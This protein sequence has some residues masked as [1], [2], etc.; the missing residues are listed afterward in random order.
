[1]TSVTLRAVLD[2]QMFQGLPERE[3]RRLVAVARRRRFERR[4][5]VFHQGDP[6]D[7]LHLVSR[8]H[9]AAR[10]AT[11]LGNTTTLSVHGPGEAFGELAIV[12]PDSARSTT[13]AALEAGE[14]YAVHRTDFGRL[15]EQ[16]PSVND[17]LV[18]LLARRLR[19][20]GDLLAEALFVPAE[21]R[22]LR[23]LL[24]VAA[25]YRDGAV[26]LRQEDLAGLAGTS[27]ATVNRVLRAEA[28]RGS[29]ELRRGKT[30]VVDAGALARRA[31]SP[32]L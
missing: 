14:T 24:E 27:R 8:G 32:L 1:V 26:P 22:V 30:V 18:R 15:R 11:R 3:L 12:E 19:R 5:I 23:R 7:T 6:A 21:T 10:I 20:A 13:V 16:Y 17:L 25:L 2:W 4:E 9:F 28:E 31:G 29:V